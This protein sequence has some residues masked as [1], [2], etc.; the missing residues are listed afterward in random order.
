MKNLIILFNLSNASKEAPVI[1]ILPHGNP[2]TRTHTMQGIA[3]PTI[4]LELQ[5]HINVRKQLTSHQ[6]NFFLYFIFTT[7][8][9]KLY[10]YSS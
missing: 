7:T 8:T 10:K 5:C 1:N 6:K 9:K 2:A 3:L 4:S